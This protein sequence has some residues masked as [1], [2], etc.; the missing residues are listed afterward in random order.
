MNHIAEFETSNQ[1]ESNHGAF[2]R[3][4]FFNT[5]N[6]SKREEVKVNFFDNMW[7]FNV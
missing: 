4:I 2:K 7:W 3:C 6:I 1:M 5:L